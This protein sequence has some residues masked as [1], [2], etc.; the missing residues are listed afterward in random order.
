MAP[1]VGLEAPDAVR[2]LPGT[3]WAG[4]DLAASHRAPLHPQ[5]D[6][7]MPVAALAPEVRPGLHLRRLRRPMPCSV[8]P[9]GLETGLVLQLGGRQGARGAPAAPGRRSSGASTRPR[10]P[11]APPFPPARPAGCLGPLGRG[12]GPPSQGPAPRNWQ[13]LPAPDGGAVREGTPRLSGPGG[14]LPWHLWKE[15]MSPADLGPR[16]QRVFK[17]YQAGHKYQ[18]PPEAGAGWTGPGLL[19]QLKA[20]VT[21]RTLHPGEGPFSAPEWRGVLPQRDLVEELGPLHTCAVVSSAGSLQ[22]SG[23]GKEIHAHEAELRFNAAP[24][25]GYERDVGSKTTLRLLNSQLMASKEHHFLD[26]P[27]YDSGGLVA[28]DQPR[29]QPTCRSS[30]WG[31][32]GAAPPPGRPRRPH[33][34]A[35]GLHP[36]FQWQLWDLLQGSAAEVVRG[37]VLMTS[38]CR[39]VQ[40]CEFLPSQRRTDRCHEPFREAACS[41]GAY[42]PLLFEKSLVLAG[43]VAPTLTSPCTAGSRCQGSAP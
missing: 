27:L 31:G 19:C 3:R 2:R 28:W 21:V 11:T 40:L 25:A 20:R 42:H 1:L 33:Q 9:L 23:L 30:G 18:V 29:T 8:V 15:E 24:T 5:A 6:G 12:L 35:H 37:T 32:A 16:L 39:L 43:T 26:N 36:Q 34:A 22:N 14:P 38:L 4:Q 13:L 7:P 41:L 10:G 17:S